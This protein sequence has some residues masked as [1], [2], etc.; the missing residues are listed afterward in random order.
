MSSSIYQMFNHLVREHHLYSGKKSYRIWLKSF[1]S[2]EEVVYEVSLIG[3][4]EQV[5]KK[6]KTFG[7]LGILESL[8]NVKPPGR[9]DAVLSVSMYFLVNNL[10]ISS[11]IFK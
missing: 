3:L 4:K 11:K 1:L 2:H 9:C 7:T 6:R 5:D 8:K 10:S